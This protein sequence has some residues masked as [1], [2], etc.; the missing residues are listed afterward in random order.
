M[1]EHL[2]PYLC[3]Y[4]TSAGTKNSFFLFVPV[5]LP[6]L[7]SS[8]LDGIMQYLHVVLELIFSFCTGTSTVLRS[9][10]LDGIMLYLQVVLEL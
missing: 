10:V 3:T 2:R 1:Y 4:G 6:V 5:H 7:R 9:S 8:V